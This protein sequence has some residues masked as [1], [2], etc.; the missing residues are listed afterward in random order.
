MVEALRGEHELLL[1]ASGAA[2]ALLENVY[3][4]AGDV[5]VLEIPGL[6]FE[7]RRLRLDYFRSLAKSIPFLLKLPVHVNLVAELLR[8]ERPQLAICDFEPLLPRAAKRVGVPLLSFDHQH[9]LCVS[10]LSSLPWQLRL[11]AWTIGLS[12]GLF[13]SGQRETVVSSF[14]FPPLRPHAGKVSQIGVLLRPEILQTV[15]QDRGHVLVYLRRFIR[16][17]LADALR[18]IDREVRI[19]GL[20]ELPADGNLRFHAVDESKFVSDLATCHA[21]ISTAGNQLVGEALYLRKPFLA[22]PEP[23]N[24]E[25]A[26]NA[27]FLQQIRGG[28]VRDYERFQPPDL[29]EFLDAVPV[30]R[31]RI[32][33]SRIVGNEEALAVIRRHLPQ[34]FKLASPAPAVQVA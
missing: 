28:M 7:Y 4:R 29:H 8:R 33:P 21:V 14:F 27:H 12:V 26:V 13:C 30:L 18:A 20:G 1:L 2:Y 31:S 5:R 15:P 34:D 10:Q 25:Q 22:L 17:N 9:F 11:R 23:G 24:F 3:Q 6:R 16:H 32:N 19:Y